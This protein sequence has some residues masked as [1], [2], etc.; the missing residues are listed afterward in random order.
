MSFFD[1]TK[2]GQPAKTFLRLIILFIIISIFSFISNQFSY[3]LGNTFP[4]S[5]TT[6]QSEVNQN[7]L[8]SLKFEYKIVKVVDGDTLDIE[9]IDGEK[10]LGV[11]DI[12]R[13]RLLGINSP[14]TVDP[15][16]PVECYGKEA[17]NYLKNIAT[18]KDAALELDASQGNFDKY[19]RVLAYV[20]IKK[21]GVK[22]EN[23][24][25][26]NSDMLKNGYAFEYTY[27]KKYKYQKDFKDI[28]SA[29]KFSHVGLW[30][31]NTCNGLKIPIAPSPTN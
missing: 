13:V 1:L 20:Y 18:G 21:E 23:I 10:V 26:L 4:K 6:I 22:D 31:L 11:K 2:I 16:K 29:S 3:Y 24:F 25:M 27:D 28:E 5:D 15:R 7:F 12:E 9:R 8:S 14:E 30:S 19:G 17:S